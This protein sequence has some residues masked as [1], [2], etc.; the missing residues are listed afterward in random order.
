MQRAGE[1]QPLRTIHRR[2]V[3]LELHPPQ[4]PVPWQ[5]SRGTEQVFEEIVESRRKLL[6]GARRL[7]TPRRWDSPRGPEHRASLSTGHPLRTGVL[8]SLARAAT[9]GLEAIAQPA[10]YLVISPVRAARPAR[11][12]ALDALR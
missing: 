3:A 7:D 1:A 4:R 6:G 11:T 10:E 12:L 5:P 9:A 8:A 2:Y